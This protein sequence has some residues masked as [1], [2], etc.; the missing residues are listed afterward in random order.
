MYHTLEKLNV[1]IACKSEH[2]EEIGHVEH[3]SIDERIIA[4]LFIKN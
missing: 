2:L 1:F 4:I 3:L